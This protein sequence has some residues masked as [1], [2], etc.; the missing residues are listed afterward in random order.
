M[1]A[2]SNT[3]S[4]QTVFRQRLT[5]LHNPAVGSGSLQ[6]HR[7]R[8]WDSIGVA[9]SRDVLL[10]GVGVFPPL[11]GGGGWKFKLFYKKTKWELMLRLETSIL[12]VD[13]RPF[14][15]SD[16]TIPRPIDTETPLASEE[17]E[18]G[19]RALTIYAKVRSDICH[20]SKTN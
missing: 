7:R 6:E 16:D 15:G 19:R 20:R 5:R 13:A 1:Q 11:G 2:R 17:E 8:D 9:A 14:R 12:S 18:D 3:I 10:T 4:L